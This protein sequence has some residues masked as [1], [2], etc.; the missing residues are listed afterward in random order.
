MR[1]VCAMVLVCAA[2]VLLASGCGPVVKGVKVTGSVTQGGKP[3]EGVTVGF[4]PADPKGEAKAARTDAEG[5]FVL[6]MEPG[7]YTVT[8][9]KFVDK[10]GNVPKESD[11]PTEDFT[12]LEASGYLRQVLPATYTNPGTSPFK[13][14]IPSGGKDL[15]PFDLK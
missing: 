12:Q 14:E 13:V 3:Q 15:E 11:N 1:H 8:L 2:F 9:T 7:K 10:K 4:G 6:R 5:K